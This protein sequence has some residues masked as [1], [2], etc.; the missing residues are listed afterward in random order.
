MDAMIL[1]LQKYARGLTLSKNRE[2]A[3]ELWLEIAFVF[4]FL[5][6]GRAS[7]GKEAIRRKIYRKNIAAFSVNN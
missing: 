5:Y 6:K 4:L 1:I 7:K 2:H 3:A